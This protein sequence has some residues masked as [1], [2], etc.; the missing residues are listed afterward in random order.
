MIFRRSELT[1]ARLAREWPHWVAVRADQVAARHREISAFGGSPS[2][3]PRHP[4]VRR[5]DVDYVVFCF[6]DPDHA[7]RF[8]LA[9]DGPT[10]VHARSSFGIGNGPYAVSRGASFGE[11]REVLFGPCRAPLLFAPRWLFGSLFLLA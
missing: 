9:F 10:F 5:N 6:A 8:R 3:A 11:R 2:L 4:T 7:E 1:S